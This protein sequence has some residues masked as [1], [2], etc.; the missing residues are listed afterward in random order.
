MKKHLFFLPVLLLSIT[1][2]CQFDFYATAINLAVDGNAVYYN[3]TSPGNDQAIGSLP[4]QNASIGTFH[5]NSGNLKVTG[6]EVKTFKGSSGNTCSATLFFTVYKE[7]E[8][9]QAPVYTSIGL[10][11]YDN[12]VSGACENFEGH[13][14]TLGCCKLGDQ[15]WQFPG[16]GNGGG[17]DGNVDITSREPGDYILEVYYRI[18][19]NGNGTD[20][21]DNERYDNNSSAPANYTARFSISPSLPV[22]FG[23]ISAIREKSGNRI[24]W[25]TYT[26]VGNQSF[27]VERSPDAKNFET[28]GTVAAKGNS[29]N[30]S[31]YQFF[32]INPPAL[33]AYYRVKTTF[34]GS[35]QYSAIVK[36]SYGVAAPA[37]T[38]NPAASQTLLSGLKAGSKIRIINT[39]GATIWQ[40]TAAS[41]TQI[42]RLSNYPAGRY[43]VQIL[44]AGK[45]TSLPLLINK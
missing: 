35:I 37:L 5:Q 10:G 26:E 44:E 45:A 6:A 43:T 23:T 34:N 41:P 3:N 38:P 29:T 16:G 2:F 17:N 22:H 1:A 12:C 18:T 19:G 33:Q 25:N 36:A 21:C 40:A 15:K 28:I 31:N 27:F 30:V 9:P 32:D 7:G 11:F 14:N 24:S 4:F 20:G 42:I 13:Y 39:V 8:R